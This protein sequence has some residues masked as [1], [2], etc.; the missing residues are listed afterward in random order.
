MKALVTAAVGA[1]AALAI[2]AGNPHPAEAAHNGFKI[3]P[4]LALPS[5]LGDPGYT[6][7]ISAFLNDFQGWLQ[8]RTFRSETFAWRPIQVVQL[9]GTWQ[10]YCNFEPSDPEYNNYTEGQKNCGNG[11]DCCVVWNRVHADLVGPLGYD[12]WATSES[13]HHTVVW[14]VGLGAFAGGAS[15]NPGGDYNPSGGPGYAL[16]GDFSLILLANHS[17][18]FGWGW[19]GENCANMPSLQYA[20]SQ[21]S[22]RGAAAQ[23]MLHGWRIPH[24]NEV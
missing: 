2:S 5:N 18:P 22:Q 19:L 14:L 6:P 3:D 23:E 15:I 10:Y 12:P 20:C 13:A 16:L 8:A 1:L 17:L 21:T 24:C 4:V 11:N 7:H 9:P